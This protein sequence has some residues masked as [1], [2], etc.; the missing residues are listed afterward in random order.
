FPTRRSSDLPSEPKHERRLRLTHGHRELVSQP[1]PALQSPAGPLVN[2]AAGQNLRGVGIGIDNSYVNCCAPP[3]TNGAAGATQY[4]QWVNL[5]SAVCDNT[6]GN[7]VEG[8][9]A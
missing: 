7:P 9:P 8:P 3:D 2:T 1:D 5:D 6:P 4:V